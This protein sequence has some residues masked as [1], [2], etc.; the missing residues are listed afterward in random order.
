M[1]CEHLR[2]LEEDIIAAGIAETARG[3]LWSE[4]CREWVYFDC[5]IDRERVEA[6]Y[7]FAECVKYHEHRGTHDGCEAGFECT[8]CK[9]G[10]MGVHE[11]HA[12]GRPVFE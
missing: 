3:Q 7:D 1:V 9:D 5:F 8:E 10:V 2:K 4:N 12:E 11:C 6:R